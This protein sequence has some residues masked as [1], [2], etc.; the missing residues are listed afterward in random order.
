MIVEILDEQFGLCPEKA[1]FW[2]SEK[3]LLISDLHL[4]KINHFRRSGIPV[5][6][7]ANDHN[8]EVLVDL[9]DNC[10]P[11]R[12]ICL[13]DLF[14]SHYNAEWETFGEVVKHYSAV[15]FDLVQGNHDIMGGYQYVRKG[16]RVH[17]SLQ[18]GKFLLTHHPLDTVPDGMYNIAGHIHPA[19][20]LRGRGRQ[21]ITL[22]CFCFGER[23]ALLPA[24]GKF[25]GL[26]K[27]APGKQDRIFIVAED[28]VMAVS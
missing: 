13:G 17:D 2:K 19:V 12:V 23:Q 28:R 6:H 14:H 11:A 22:P 24:F 5:P 27:I 10:K 25:T 15:V 16:I 9:I 7:K 18:I 20:S 21:A 4:G 1:V 3:A 8:L 26:A